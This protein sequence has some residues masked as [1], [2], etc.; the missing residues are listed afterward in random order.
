MPMW[1][2]A[3]LLL[4]SSAAAGTSPFR[5][6]AECP[7]MVVVPAGEFQMG[8]AP[9]P[10]LP[11]DEAPVRTVDIAHPFAMSRYEITVSQFL[12]FATETRRAPTSDCFV[13]ENGLGKSSP[14]KDWV[15]PN[16]AQTPEHPVVCVDWQ[17]ANAYAQW[18]SAKTGQ[19]YRLPTE[20]E[21]EYAAGESPDDLCRYGNIADLSVAVAVGDW[22]AVNRHRLRLEPD[23]KKIALDERFALQGPSYTVPWEV[24]RCDDGVAL[25]AASVGSYAANRYG[26]YD[27]FG[28]VWEWTADC[29]V[30]GYAAAPTNGD[31]VKVEPCKMRSLRGGAW[32]MN[33]D[34][35]RRADRDRDG[36]DRRYS[37]LG[38][39]LVRELR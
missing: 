32:A 34:G 26:L 8:S 21:W 28:N 24:A 19:I 4:M 7:E 22:R 39:R 30:D 17:D 1:A 6:C 5:D 10:G 38:I 35:W 27:M 37:V 11:S 16:Y 33:T 12:S 25:S 14:G 9:A 18:L 3:A 29:F 13:W 15:D 36:P 23:P 2:G 20:A 31:A